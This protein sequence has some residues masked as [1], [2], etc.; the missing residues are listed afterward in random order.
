MMIITDGDGD[1]AQE[2]DASVGL[3]DARCPHCRK[4]TSRTDISP[5][6]PPRRTTRE[7]APPP[8]LRQE[9][10]T[11][12]D[13]RGVKNR[14]RTTNNDSGTQTRCFMVMMVPLFGNN[15]A[16]QERDDLG[17]ELGK[18]AD[19]TISY[20]TQLAK[21]AN[22]KDSTGLGICSRTWVGLT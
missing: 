8:L 16:M 19:S 15:I 7:A 12:K 17:R 6:P 1:G 14:Q 21:S 11:M 5:A 4:K 13:E 2:K 9:M 20:E 3:D 10:I 18:E 22:A